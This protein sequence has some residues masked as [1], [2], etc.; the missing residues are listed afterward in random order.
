MLLKQ[1]STQILILAPLAHTRLGKVTRA[2]I[3]GLPQSPFTTERGGERAREVSGSL[4]IC[5]DDT[6]ARSEAIPS[7]WLSGHSSSCLLKH[8]VLQASPPLKI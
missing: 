8:V 4:Q 7:H 5:S 2:N 3:P 1:I 6:V